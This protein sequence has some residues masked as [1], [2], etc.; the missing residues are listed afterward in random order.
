MG[1]GR[2]DSCIAMAF[3]VKVIP[4]D[5]LSGR[6]YNINKFP[7]KRITFPRTDTYSPLARAVSDV[8]VRGGVWKA[9]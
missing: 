6:L 2:L 5:L 1:W 3:F 8:N 4:R 7:S 9:G